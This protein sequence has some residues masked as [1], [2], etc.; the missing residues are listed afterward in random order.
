M[1][2]TTSLV[3]AQHD[4]LG[5]SDYKCKI[6][7]TNTK[8]ELNGEIYKTGDTSITLKKAM[9]SEQVFN[10]TEFSLMPIPVT[11][12]DYISIYK[13]GSAGKGLLIGGITGMFLGGLIGLAS[14]DDK[15][16]GPWDFFV[17]TAG[18]KAGIG[19]VVGFIPGALIGLAA[20]SSKIIIG[21]HGNAD[22]Y[23]IRRNELDHYSIKN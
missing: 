23:K 11:R 20:G 13:K 8:Y 18:E 4:T 2:L 12:I 16:D 17:L 21:I 22:K 5:N 14:G 10:K 7:L 19:A 1:T 6:V 3:H 9:Y 15:P